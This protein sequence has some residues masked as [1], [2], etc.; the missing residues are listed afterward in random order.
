MSMTSGASETS[1]EDESSVKDGDD[2]ISGCDP[3]PKKTTNADIFCVQME[4]CDRYVEG[5]IFFCKTS[6]Q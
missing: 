5:R 6:S 3:A 4:V 1:A 2:V